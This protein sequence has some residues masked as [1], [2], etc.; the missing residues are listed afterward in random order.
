MAR[1]TGVMH[2]FPTSRA[3]RFRAPGNDTAP[4][5]RIVGMYI[6]EEKK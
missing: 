6:S 5:A 2:W 4:G 3:V 1:V